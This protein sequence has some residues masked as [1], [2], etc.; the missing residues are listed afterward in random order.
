MQATC[1]SVPGS[2]VSSLHLGQ[3]QWRTDCAIFSTALVALDYSNKHSIHA[4]KLT[5]DGQT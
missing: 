1:A 2:S 4:A 5:I 3:M